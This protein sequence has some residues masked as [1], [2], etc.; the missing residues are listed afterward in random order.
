MVAHRALHGLR[1]G[2]D[3]AK[4]VDEKIEQ[5]RRPENQKNING[6]EQTLVLRYPEDLPVHTEGENGDQHPCSPTCRSG[7]LTTPV[8]TCHQHQ[9]QEDG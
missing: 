4:L 2:L 8:E 9:D 5:Q 6:N 1:D 7:F 3:A